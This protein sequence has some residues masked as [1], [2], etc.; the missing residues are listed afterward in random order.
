MADQAISALTAYTPPIDTD[1]FVVVD[2]STGETK[3]ITWA[4]LRGLS[5]IFKN[6]T[7][8]YDLATASG[9]QTIAHGVGKIPK[10][11]RITGLTYITSGGS[12]SYGVYNGTTTSCVYKFFQGSNSVGGNDNTNI[13]RIYETYNNDYQVATVTVDATNI[14]LAWGKTGTPTQTAYIMWEAVG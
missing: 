14:T 10:Y 4:N 8:T 13:I 1:V 3:K 2:V 7:T 5:T 12:Q 11:V 9:N 6:G